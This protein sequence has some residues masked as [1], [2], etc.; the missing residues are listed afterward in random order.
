MRAILYVGS[1]NACC[2]LFHEQFQNECRQ[3]GQQTK[4]DIDAADGNECCAW[5][6]E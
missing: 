3:C 1:N 2:Y 6:F 4:E 5:N